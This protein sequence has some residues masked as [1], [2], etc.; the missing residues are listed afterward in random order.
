MPMLPE[1]INV[2][3]GRGADLTN[4]WS[5]LKNLDDFWKVSCDYLDTDTDSSAWRKW[6]APMFA[7]RTN[8]LPLTF[9]AQQQVMSPMCHNRVTKK[10]VK[11]N[12][13]IKLDLCCNLTFSPL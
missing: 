3:R 12:K 11:N 7:Q 6:L 1:P 2:V 9:L 13:Q 8:I 10:I 4:D 5:I